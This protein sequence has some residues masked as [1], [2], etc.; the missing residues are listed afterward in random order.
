MKFDYKIKIN[1]FSPFK[2]II[3]LSMW[4]KL[5]TDIFNGFNNLIYITD[6]M[7]FIV[8]VL[9]ISK[10]K[11]SNHE[12]IIPFALVLALF[13][14]DMAYC[15]FKNNSLLLL[16]WGIRNHYRF[17]V[18]FLG[19]IC[20]LT[21]FDVKSIFRIVEKMLYINFVIVIVEV[22]M[23]YRQ[24]LLSG[25]FGIT[26]GTNN[27]ANLFLCIAYISLLIDFL[28]AETS[29]MKFI[30][31]FLGMFLWAALAEL[32]YFILQ[33]VIFS[34]VA[35]LVTKQGKIRKIILVFLGVTLGI[36]AIGFM[37]SLNPYYSDF[38]SFNSIKNYAQNIGLGAGGYTRTNAIPVINLVFFR[39]NVWKKLFGIG[40]GQGEQSPFSFL[41]SSFY[42]E[43]KEYN[44][45]SLFYGSVYVERGLLGIIWYCAFF[46]VSAMKSFKLK[47]SA[48]KNDRV[49]LDK[50]I[51]IVVCCFT[52]MIYDDA[53][54]RTPCGFLVY[55]LL[56][57]PFI[58]TKQQKI[59]NMKGT[60]K[61]AGR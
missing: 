33:S 4:L 34:I 31:C 24:D 29:K 58:Y 45:N 5:A 52:E 8:L 15:I 16:L 54:R 35:I 50:S 43:F 37:V 49:L 22:I 57:V 39:D 17:F 2:I 12:L 25:T 7:V 38:F 10:F 53:I 21:T 26:I 11:V 41:N 9:V 14:W 1:T 36:I 20:L 30:L 61:N 23:G 28:Y 6:A 13:I 44:Y 18:I 42:N 47:K 48:Y 56:A 19:G 60:I 51:L 55:L 59:I 3:V 32:K 46:L 27:G 40:L